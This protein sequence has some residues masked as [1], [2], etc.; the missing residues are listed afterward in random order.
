[1][2]LR[3]KGTIVRGKWVLGR[4]LAS[5]HLAGPILV[6]LKEEPSNIH[7]LLFPLIF[8]QLCWRRVEKDANLWNMQPM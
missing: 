4:A 8:V 6:I 2:T 1:M 3:S 7:I 5:V